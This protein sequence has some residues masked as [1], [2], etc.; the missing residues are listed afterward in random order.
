MTAKNLFVRDLNAYY[1]NMHILHN[2]DLAI[3]AEP[4]VIIG[5]NGMG[6]STLCK[7]LMGL[8]K[9]TGSLKFGDTDLLHLHSFEISRLGIG[10][11]PQGRRIFPSLTVDE[12]LKLLRKNTT[13]N[14]ERVYELFP[15]LKERRSNFGNQLS[16]GEQQMLA[17]GRALLTNPQLLVM[18]EPTEGLAPIVVDL[19]ISTLTSLSKE[20]MKLLVV[21]QDLR[22]ATTL[23]KSVS[24][25]VNGR[26]ETKIESQVLL[27][28][29]ELKAK[30]LGLH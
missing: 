23:A 25:M 9:R 24:I 6:K 10:Y 26:I 18:D 15:R 16:G 19:V 3:G 2:L 4:L 28:D 13:W 17:I 8:V 30:Y 7:S 27:T 20:G 14:A 22:V 5:R 12:H 1:G 29:D 21:E 11:V